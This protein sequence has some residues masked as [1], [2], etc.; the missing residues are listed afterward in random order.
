MSG[1]FGKGYGMFS[2]SPLP[3]KNQCGFS[4]LLKKPRI[5]PGLSTHSVVLVRSVDGYFS[6]FSKSRSKSPRSFA[7][8]QRKFIIF[9]NAGSSSRMKKPMKL[10]FV[11]GL[12][13]NAP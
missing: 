9:R 3:E 11:S 4:S 10:I 13:V 8:F 7:S 12:S 6:H 2:I 1:V 5:S